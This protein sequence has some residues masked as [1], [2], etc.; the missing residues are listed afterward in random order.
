[1]DEASQE[2]SAETVSAAEAQQEKAT[3]EWKEIRSRMK[4]ATIINASMSDPER[5]AI[6]RDKSI[7]AADYLGQAEDIIAE[8]CKSLDSGKIGLI[9][10]ALKRAAQEFGLPKSLINDDMDMTVEVSI[11]SL[12]ESAGKQ[13]DNAEQL[14]KLL[15]VLDEAVQNAV[16]IEMHENRYYFDDNTFCFANLLGGFS[17][18]DRFVPVRFGIKTSIDGTNNLYVLISNQGIEKAEV[19]KP[20]ATDDS[21]A[22]GSRSTYEVSIPLLASKI[23]TP[24]ILKYL[25]DEFLSVRQ[26]KVKWKAIA[27][28]VK[29]TNDKNDKKY[30]DYLEKGNFG[31]LQRMVEAAAKANGYTIKAWHGTTAFFTVFCKGDIGYHVGSMEQA[32]DRVRGIE[33]ARIMPLFVKAN[34]LLEIGMDYGDWGG[35]NVALKLLETGVFED[36]PEIEEKLR[37]ILKIDRTKGKESASQRKD[38]A[39][40]E[41]LQSIGYDGIVYENAF[42]GHSKL[43]SGENKSYIVFDSSQLKSADPVTYDDDGN[44]IPLSERFRIDRT[45]E[46]AWE[47]ED[48]RYRLKGIN[49]NGIEVFETSD[50]VKKMP[51]PQREAAYLDMISNQYRGRTAR[52]EKNGSY[53]YATFDPSNYRKPVYGEKRSSKA[54]R[55]ALLRVAADGDVFDLLERSNYERSEPNRKNHTSADYFDYFVKTV[56]IDNKV[57]DLVADVEKKYS[58]ND[59]G[60]VY[61]LALTDNKKMK[62]APATQ[63]VP[64]LVN[65]AD[66]PSFNATV[67]QPKAVVKSESRSRMKSAALEEST[68][69]KHLDDYASS[70]PKYAQAY[71]TWMT[72]RQFVELTSS[73]EYEKIIQEDTEVKDDEWYKE[74]LRRQPFQLWIDSKTGQVDSQEGRHRAV[75]FERKGIERIPV[76]LFDYSNKYGKQKMSDYTLYGRD[77]E[78]GRRATAESVNVQDVIPLSRENK[79]EIVEKFS[80]PQKGGDSFRYRF[81]DSADAF[82]YREAAKEVS[83]TYVDYYAVKKAVETGKAETVDGN[84]VL[85]LLR[86]CK[87][88]FYCNRFRNMVSSFCESIWRELKN[89]EKS[90]RK[91]GIS[92]DFDRHKAADKGR[93]ERAKIREGVF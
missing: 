90:C 3:E 43:H 25:P 68:V 32:K 52:F 83:T 59:E 93:K 51:T 2:R 62:A 77:F 80:N 16:G 78:N 64:G 6:L 76:L 30:R 75:A 82:T 35:T 41:L 7:T 73:K 91:S 70:N 34:N 39:I 44:I 55:N 74:R 18:N 45:G 11:G 49:A 42:E 69:E 1:M 14:M 17:E 56:Q 53:F 29:Y 40:R 9:K 4:D 65:S 81:K 54:G 20:R 13:I 33:N 21:A 38:R 27:E 15:P 23:N 79:A 71:I 72:P 47:N 58:N 19:I 24:D 84:T 63:P 88:F 89:E 66:Q 28:T 22:P 50:K 48:I 36:N 86:V 60:Y 57:Y 12:K 37:K 26:K 10:S 5:A 92:F 46:E 87:R 8:E 67:S 31:S 61:T 85:E